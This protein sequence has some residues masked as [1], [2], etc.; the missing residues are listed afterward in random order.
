VEVEGGAGQVEVALVGE[1]IV[2]TEVLEAGGRERRRIRL[3]AE[4]RDAEGLIAAAACQL[5][6]QRRL[7]VELPRETG[8][9]EVA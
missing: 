6:E 8:R 2:D 9:D 5:G 7:R 3:G 1:R 4:R